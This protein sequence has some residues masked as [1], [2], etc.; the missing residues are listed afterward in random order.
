[1]L[2][3]RNMLH[4]DD[5]ARARPLREAHGAIG[6]GRDERPRHG[7]VL[8]A[9]GHAGAEGL[10]MVIQHSRVRIA[11]LT[12]ERHRLVS[13]TPVRPILTKSELLL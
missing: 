10:R 4:I 11:G 6:V 13:T 9:I 2:F 1:M 8:G 5:K 12:A 3:I 7:C